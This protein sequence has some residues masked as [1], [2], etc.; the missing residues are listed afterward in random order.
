MAMHGAWARKLEAVHLGALGVW[1]GAL[2][3]VSATAALAFPT[4]KG[5]QPALPGYRV[6]LMEH[7]QIAAGHMMNPV[8]MGVM[9]GGTACAALALLAWRSMGWVRRALSVV[10]VLLAAGTLIGVGL[11]MQDHLHA[12]WEAARAGELEAAAGAK[13]RFDALHPWSSRA[14]GTQAALVLLALVVGAWSA[15]GTRTREERAA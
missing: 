15:G 4:M 14:L 2:V 6:D 10:L 9:V 13:Q 11:A 3:M 7:P 12:Y 8:F 1:L 5:L